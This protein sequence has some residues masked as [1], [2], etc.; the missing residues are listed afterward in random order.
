MPA[1][2]LSNSGARDASAG[3]AT[4]RPAATDSDYEPGPGPGFKFSRLGTHGSGHARASS[5][6]AGRIPL[7]EASGATHPE[8]R[9]SAWR[10]PGGGGSG[11]R[12]GVRQGMTAP[13]RIRGLLRVQFSRQRRRA[14]GPAAPPNALAKPAPRRPQPPDPPHHSRLGLRPGHLR[15]PGPGPA[16]PVRCP[17]A[18]AKA[19]RRLG[20]SRGPASPA[21][22]P[23]S[24]Q[25]T[26]LNAKARAAR[27]ARPGRCA[28]AT[29]GC[30]P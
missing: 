25:R 21:P 5:Q 8:S 3:R 28:S 30:R 19:A 12:R 9:A 16:G 6:G 4:A 15:L 23:P 17:A 14:A 26:E 18:S 11:P 10:V 1:R 13:W 22:P 7:R 2:T 29:S 24:P 20:R 27:G